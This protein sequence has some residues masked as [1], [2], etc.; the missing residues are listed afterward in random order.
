MNIDGTD[1]KMVSTGK[2]RTTCSY[3]FPH[4]EKILYSSTHLADAACPPRPDYSKAMFGRCIR[5]STFSRR[6][7]MIGP[8]T[9]YDDAGVRCGGHDF[10]RRQ[11]DVFTSLRNGDLDIYSMDTDGKHVKQL[12]HELGYDGGPFF[13]KTVSGLFIGPTIP[14]R[15]RRS[16]ST[17]NC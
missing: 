7:S 6:I 12:T 1:Q 11:E 10:G 17:R 14:R 5:G 2:G 8:Q 15:T 9:A 3:I 13:P 4:N 16:R